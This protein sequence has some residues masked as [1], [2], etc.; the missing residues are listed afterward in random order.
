[1]V[2]DSPSAPRTRK[3]ASSRAR[4]IDAARQVF[5]EDGFLDARITDIAERAGLG[6][7]TFYHYFDSK[8]AILREVAAAL[9]DRLV[10]P[11]DEAVFT[12]ASDLDPR[13][14]IRQGTRM[15]LERY[16]K[17]ARLI[18]EVDRAEH[19]DVQLQQARREHSRVHA[20]LVAASIR[21]HQRNGLADA[22]LDPQVVAHAMSAIA[23]RFADLW[24]V[25]KLIDLSFESAVD[26]LTTLMCNAIGVPDAATAGSKR[27][28]G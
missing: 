2:E 24:A 6:H 21:Q 18:S 1:V 15:Y 19:L 25:Q 5:E 23:N 17:E 12:I 26:Q 13:E 4:L 16:K 22:R 14:Q 11:I 7:G 27:A 28:K 3:G 9:A 8:E 20:K 10:P